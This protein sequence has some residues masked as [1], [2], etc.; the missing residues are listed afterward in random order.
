MLDR[1][2]IELTLI[3]AAQQQGFTLNG[4]DMLDIRTS[5]AASLA[6]KDRHR[7]RMNTP[8]YQWKKPEPRR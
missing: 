7:Q 8:A 6:A 5:V 2:A 1:Q 4:K 3:S